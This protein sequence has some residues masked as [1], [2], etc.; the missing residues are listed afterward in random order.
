MNAQLIQ[1]LAG[2]QGMGPGATPPTWQGP[3]INE[4]Q[5]NLDQAQ[6]QQQI[7]QQMMNK[8]YQ[9]GGWGDVLAMALGGFMGNK[10]MKQGQEAEIQA[11]KQLDNKSVNDSMHKAALDQQ[12]AIQKASEEE[13]ARQAANQ[14]KRDFYQFQQDNKSFNPNSGTNVTLNTG[15]PQYGKIEPGFQRIMDEDGGVR[16]VPIEGSDAAIERSQ[17]ATKDATKTANTFL[18]ADNINRVIDD[19]INSADGMTTGLGGS[20]MKMIPGTGASDME[21]NLKT[22]EAD[23]AFSELQNMRDNSKTGGALGQVSEREL[24]L[25]S[26]AK[27]ALS[28]SQSPEQFKENL[29][30][31]KEVRNAAM[32]NV[33]NA[34]KMDHGTFPQ[35]YSPGGSSQSQPSQ[36]DDLNAMGG[37]DEIKTINGKQYGMRGG[38]V[39]EL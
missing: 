1:A 37:Y 34:Y 16:D 21:A 30:R 39:Y 33:A 9:G 32:E 3:G 6:I 13:R 27:A 10:K 20:L 29:L 5:G 4:M 12:L 11:L 24:A 22:V 18:Q 38:K 7:A 14:E 28:Q 25:L 36:A 15:K 8:Q 31:Y 26:S 35:G 19:V 2:V 23:A 17:N